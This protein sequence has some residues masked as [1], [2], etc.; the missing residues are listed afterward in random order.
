MLPCVSLYEN[1]L[2]F[3]RVIYCIFSG[4]K[5]LGHFHSM[6]PDASLFSRILGMCRLMFICLLEFLDISIL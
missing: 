6:M 3:L 2:A 4:H 5:N 1:A